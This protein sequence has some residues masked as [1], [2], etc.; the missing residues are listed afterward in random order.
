MFVKVID[1]EVVEYPYALQTLKLEN[2]HTGF[3]KVMSDTLLAEYNIYKVV[4]NDPPEFD[5]NTQKLEMD[6][7]PILI[8]GSWQISHNLV[9]LNDEELQQKQREKS[10]GNYALIQSL[11]SQTDHWALQDTPDMTDVQIAYRSSLRTLDQHANW[12][13]LEDADWPTKP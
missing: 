5:V 9:Q 3:P 6:T 11:L 7:M 8:N 4:Y 2:P 12:P 13:Y 1:N 10:E